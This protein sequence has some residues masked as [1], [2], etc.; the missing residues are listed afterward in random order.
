MFLIKLGIFWSFYII[1]LY[2]KK[3]SHYLRKI[4]II[5]IE[6]KLSSIYRKMQSESEM[7][8]NNQ[9][10]AAKS[11]VQASENLNFSKVSKNSSNSK[12]K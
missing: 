6:L 4:P 8:H 5:I 1:Q 2:Y 12:I 3:F 9:I 11:K 10:S 7:R